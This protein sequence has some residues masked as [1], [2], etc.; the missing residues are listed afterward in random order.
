MA[1]A[2]AAL[3]SVTVMAAAP[4]QTDSAPLEAQPAAAPA[5]PAPT[6]DTDAFDDLQL[7]PR[8]NAG[9]TPQPAPYNLEL[10][11]AEVHRPEATY[12]LTARRWRQM[13]REDPQL[14]HL[15]KRGR[16]VIPGAIFL[17][18]S[19]VWLSISTAVALDSR[20][21]DWDSSHVERL[22]QWGLPAAMLVSGAVMTFVGAKARRDLR[23]IQQRLYVAPYMAK[24]SGGVTFSARF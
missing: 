15:H 14:W 17:S 10:S 20:G 2:L 12:K 13:V 3:L 19:G 16:L 4:A 23:E 11:E 21:S 6:A 5:A 7:D 1:I 24:G 8:P 18:V 9:P 22:F